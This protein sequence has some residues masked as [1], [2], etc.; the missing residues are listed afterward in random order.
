MTFDERETLRS[1]IAE[2]ESTTELCS[3]CRVLAEYNELCPNC[4]ALYIRAREYEGAH[5]KFTLNDTEIVVGFKQSTG[6]ELDEEELAT[7][8]DLMLQ[9]ECED[10]DNI[11]EAIRKVVMSLQMHGIE[12][13]NQ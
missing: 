12:G 1:L 2:F 7:F 6:R 13:W 4:L 5:C 10:A 3:V 11:V 8:K 9:F